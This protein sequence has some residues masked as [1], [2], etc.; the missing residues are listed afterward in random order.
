[1]LLSITHESIACSLHGPEAK[2]SGAQ[3]SVD[4]ACSSA[5]VGVH[6]ARQQLGVAY[7]GGAALAAG[8]NLMLAETTTAAAQAAGMLTPDGRCKTLD[9]AADG[10]VR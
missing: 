8:V 4:T 5:L 10:Y 2:N 9:V 3:V 6:L 1:M 7:S